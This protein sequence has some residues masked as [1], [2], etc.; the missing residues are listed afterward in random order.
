MTESIRNDPERYRLIF[1]NMSSITDYY[2]SNKQDYTASCLHGQ[3]QQQQYSSPDY[4]NEANAI[5]IIDE[6]EKAFL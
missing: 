2:S 1:Y 3:H 5:I 6:A 4:D